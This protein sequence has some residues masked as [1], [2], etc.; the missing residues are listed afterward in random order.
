MEED[1]P[2][3]LVRA[4]TGG[5]GGRMS[6]QAFTTLIRSTAEA[7]TRQA[8]TDHAIECIEHV[9]TAAEHDTDLD[10]HAPIC[11]AD[12]ILLGASA[13][14]NARALGPHLAGL[15]IRFVLHCPDREATNLRLLKAMAGRRVVIKLGGLAS[16]T[17]AR[18][19]TKRS[20]LPCVSFHQV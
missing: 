3:L 16:S 11:V 5:R 19:C 12:A 2:A 14:Q 17:R 15:I 9:I 13:Q 8:N 1:L 7:A 6:R 4:A 10:M 20:S 18:M